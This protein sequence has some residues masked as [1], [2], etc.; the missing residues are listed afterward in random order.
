MSEDKSTEQVSE[1]KSAEATEVESTET[2][3]DASTEPGTTETAPRN[4]GRTALAAVAAALVI[5]LVAGVGVLFYQHLQD[6]RTEQA[7][8]DAVAAAG[9]QAVAM[10]SYNYNT[11]DNEL[12]AAADGLT[13]SFKDDYNTLVAE[14]I[15]PGA[16]E[17]KLTVQVTVQGDSVVSADPDDAVVLLFLNQITTSADAPDA[18][19]TGSR[20][21]M[22]MH[23]D[24]DRWLTGRLTPV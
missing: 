9:E 2:V 5:A 19:T 3:T 6:N 12:A 13:G 17:K 4:V 16:K 7:R 20:V 10:L 14:V 18:A 11:V 22:E 23:K 24:G 15:A 8:T 1:D 21:R